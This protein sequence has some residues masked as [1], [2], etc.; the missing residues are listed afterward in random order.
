MRVFSF[1]A[2][3][4]LLLANIFLI[5][6]FLGGCAIHPLPED[7]VHVRTYDIARQIRCETRQAVIDVLFAYLTTP[8]NMRHDNLDQ[9]SL[10]VGLKAKEAYD[11]DRDSITRFN[12]DKLTGFAHTVVGLLYKTGIAYNYDLLG[13]ETN[14]IDPTINLLR[15]L[16]ITS[17]VSLGVTG[18]FDRQRQNER[19]FTITDNFGSLLMS[20]HEDYCTG[21][22][23]A[24]NYIYPI[25]GRVGVD[26]VVK[27]FMLLTLFANLRGLNKDLGKITTV[28]GPPTM[29]DQ[30]Q[31]QTTIGTTATPKITFIPLGSGFG[32]ADAS[33]GLTV[34]RKDTHQLT[35]GLFLDKDAAKEID[36]DRK[37]I[38]D[39]PRVGETAVAGRTVFRNLLTASGG[40]AEQGAALAV[41]QFLAQKI[42]KPTI[43]V[44]Q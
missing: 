40:R 3:R 30:L 12:P 21:R 44:N 34:S 24:E 31:F 39:R 2:K 13:L 7:V 22:L 26:R 20:V 43:V 23:A 16:P 19:S 1:W 15:P 42:F 36:A 10:E 29:V 25:A 6:F 5:V 17:K 18:N 35:V 14:N 9:H 27:D 33:L 11:S 28:A 4:S 37:A 8:D 38:F 41:E 32:F